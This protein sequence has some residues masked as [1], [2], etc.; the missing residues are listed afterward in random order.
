M[1]SYKPKNFSAMEPISA[2]K[3]FISYLITSLVIFSVSAFLSLSDVIGKGDTQIAGVMSV[4]LMLI[5]QLANV[6]I[7]NAILHWFFYFG[8]SHASPL[9]KGVATAAVLGVLNFLL[10]VFALDMYDICSDS[11]LVLVGAVGGNV[12]EYSSGGIVAAIIS[13]TDIHKWGL[14]RMI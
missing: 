13:V 6:L 4:E 8:D 14:F 12:V 11:M 9:A 1:R 3:I 10:S 2:K 7:A 5:L